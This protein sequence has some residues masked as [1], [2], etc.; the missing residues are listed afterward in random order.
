MQELIKKIKETEDFNQKVTILENCLTDRDV[1]I[2]GCGPSLNDYSTE[3]IKEFCKDK[4]VVCIKQSLL[5]FEDIADFHFY[6]DNNVLPYKY[7]RDTITSSSSAMSHDAVFASIWKGIEN[8]ADL[9][10]KIVDTQIEKS[11]CYTNDFEGW[12]LSKNGNRRVW[13]P[14]IIYECVFP[15]IVHM[16]PK[17][18]YTL[19]W[20][21]SD[22]KLPHGSQMSHYYPEDARRKT[23]N[24]SGGVIGK[25]AELLIE[26]SKHLDRY[27][28]RK[29]IELLVLSK[30]SYVDEGI[31][32]VSM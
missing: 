12:E 8:P 20:D 23:K 27:L 19:G 17:R 15:V 14:G 3:Q 13:G 5:R 30:N 26:S 10:F 24:P 11:L 4:V 16:N 6:N 1:I 22:P 21:Y 28:A 29:G 32:R 2:F 7:P 18:V 31:K 25:E 9:H